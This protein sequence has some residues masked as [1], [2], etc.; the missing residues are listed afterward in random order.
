M[1]DATMRLLYSR[2]QKLAVDS[3]TAVAASPEYRT[4]GLVAYPHLRRLVRAK[5]RMSPVRTSGVGVNR[6]LAPIIPSFTL[7]ALF[8]ANAPLRLQEI[9]FPPISNKAHNLYVC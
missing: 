1:R 9:L 3:V 6:N 7:T 5:P 8:S 2:W 4:E